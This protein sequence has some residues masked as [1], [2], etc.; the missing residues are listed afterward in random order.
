MAIIA[1]ALGVC[2]FICSVDDKRP[3]VRTRLIRVLTE[4]F[5]VFDT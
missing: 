3:S 2:E 5:L 1:W 4:G